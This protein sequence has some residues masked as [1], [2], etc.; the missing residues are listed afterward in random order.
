MTRSSMS[1][2][3]TALAVLTF[4]L[5]GCRRPTSD[6][7]P[8][9]SGT[10]VTATDRLGWDQATLPGTAI[11]AYTFAVYVDAIRQALDD[12]RCGDG[13]DV[14]V[15]TSRFPSLTP[16]SHTLEIVA[17]LDG[18]DSARS[19]PL[20]VNRVTGASTGALL[21]P[22][23]D[24]PPAGDAVLAGLASPT[25]LALSPDGRL[26]VTER[27]GRIRILDGR[28]SAALALTLADVNTEGGL[29]LFALALH[30]DFERN[31]YVY[32]AYA[33]RLPRGGAAYRVVRTREVG[34]TLGEV[35]SVLDGVPATAAGW[36]TIRFGPDKKLYVAIAPV[37]ASSRSS[38]YA[39]NGTVLRLNDDGSTPADS[40][41]SSPVLAE[42][43]GVPSALAWSPDG[44]LW[45]AD[46]TDAGARLWQIAGGKSRTGPG[47]RSRGNGVSCRR[48]GKYGPPARES[49]RRRDQPVSDAEGERSGRGRCASDRAHVRPSALHPAR[50]RLGLLL[51]RQRAGYRPSQRPYR[52]RSAPTEALSPV[53]AVSG[54]PRI[55]S[56]RCGGR[57]HF[58]AQAG[59]PCRPR[60]PAVAPVLQH[61]QDRVGKL[62]RRVIVD[63]VSIAV[64]F[65]QVREIADPRDDGWK[66]CHHRFHHR[67]R[68][69]F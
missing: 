25:D 10:P 6:E 69:A 30:P 40:P 39:Y 38:A 36:M 24:P 49:G 63:Q 48:G 15:C 53:N 50:R 43:V 61:P 35:A 42:G 28:G 20:R 19:E 11:A 37:A 34:N 52:A 58:V 7:P 14:V 17:V 9:D 51:H 18:Q 68:Q 4:A 29:G 26:V 59:D 3:V 60:E 31:H 55:R 57:C 1:V 27:G 64:V 44:K 8:P 67:E 32:L 65:D 21:P 41:R 66:A 46:A 47:N 33:E 2:A 62:F 23:P 56:Q 22:E 16:G 45:V 13:S 54:R 12:A 5:A